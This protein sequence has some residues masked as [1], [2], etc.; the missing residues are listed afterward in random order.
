[1]M[2]I[3]S[4]EPHFKQV[5]G[6][7]RKYRRKRILT[8]LSSMVGSRWV[9][10]GPPNGCG[11]VARRSGGVPR[12]LTEMWPNLHDLDDNGTRRKRAAAARQLLGCHVVTVSY[13]H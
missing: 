8:T 5:A 6:F 3:T 9:Q 11:C 7:P 10:C 4:L 12:M 13:T 1:M 2:G